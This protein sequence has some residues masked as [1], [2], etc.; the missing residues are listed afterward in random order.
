M[1]QADRKDVRFTAG[2][3]VEDVMYKFRPSWKGFYTGSPGGLLDTAPRR[4]RE[5]IH[6]RMANKKEWQKS[7]RRVDAGAGNAP[8]MVWSREGVDGLDE[9]NLRILSSVR[10]TAG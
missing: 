2:V 10:R 5:A 7:T 6:G 9:L 8:V 3:R 4:Q 1:D